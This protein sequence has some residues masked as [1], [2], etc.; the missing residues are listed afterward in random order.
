MRNY[1]HFWQYFA[2]FSLKWGMLQ[3]DILEKTNKHILSNNLFSGSRALFE[4]MWE[5]MV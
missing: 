2:E 4:V 5:N 1:V 3:A